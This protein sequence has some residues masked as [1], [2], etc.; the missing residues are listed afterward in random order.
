MV[1]TVF[2]NLPTTVF[3]LMSS[4]ARTHGAINLGQGF[5]EEPGPLAIREKAAEYSI[6]GPHQYAPSPGLPELRRA[7]SSFYWNHQSLDFDWNHEVTITT[8][9]SEALAASI[10]GLVNPGD[11]VIVFEPAYDLYIPVIQRAGG[12][13]RIL[14]LRPPDWTFS[15]HDLESLFSPK[16]KALILNNPMN[17]AACVFSPDKL[18]II[19]ELCARFA[20]VAICDEVWEKTIFVGHQHIPLA[21]FPEMRSR[22]VKIGSAGKLLSLTGWKVGFMMAVPELTSILRK[23]HQFLSFSVSPNL[24]RA[25][26]WGLENCPEWFDQLPRDLERSKDTLT[27]RLTELGLRTLDSQGTY[28]VNLDLAASSITED[29]MSFCLRAVK[30]HGVAAIPSSAFYRDRAVDHVLRLCCAKPDKLLNEAAERLAAARD[31][32]AFTNRQHY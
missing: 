8:G 18:A 26:A 13:P 20:V 4:L 12:I 25:V 27:A 6:E 16:T 30:Q 23:A 31:A 15:R 29:D 14:T 24:Q 22:T 10:F 19:A 2:E 5:P 11:E 17:P 28:F 7:V 1:N 21:S 9:A 3:E 32:I